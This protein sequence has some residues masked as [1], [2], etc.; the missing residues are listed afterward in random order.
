MTFRF[1]VTVTVKNDGLTQDSRSDLPRILEDTMYE[2]LEKLPWVI[3][4]NVQE[5]PIR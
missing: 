3:A 5:T 4:A 2:S 1:V